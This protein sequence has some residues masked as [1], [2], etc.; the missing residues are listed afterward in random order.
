MKRK[1]KYLNYIVGAIMAWTA[2]CA[3]ATIYTWEGTTDGNWS[4]AANW[5]V[6]GIPIVNGDG[7]VVSQANTITIQSGANAPASNIPAFSS[8]THT[9]NLGTPRFN[10]EANASLTISPDNYTTEAS[11]SPPGVAVTIA[12]NAALTWENAGK[13]TLARN[14]SDQTYNITGGT[15]IFDTPQLNIIYGSG[16]ASIFNLDGGTLDLSQVDSLYSSRASTG[17]FSS[18][19]GKI[20]LMNGSTV[21]GATCRF[22]R[23]IIDGNP[24]MVFDIQDTN[25][26]I[27]I[28]KGD[29]YGDIFSL[30]SEFGSTFISST[31]GNTNLVATDE[32]SYFKVDASGVVTIPALAKDDYETDV[33]GAKPV[34]ASSVSPSTPGADLAVVVVGGSTNIAGTGQAVRFLDNSSGGG[35]LSYNL[36]ASA[37]TQKSAVQID[38]SFASLTNLTASMGISFS[39]GGYGANPGNGNNRHIYCS[40]RGDSTID[41]T[42]SAGHALMASN[43]TLSAFV[44]DHD[45]HTI[46]YEGPDASSSNTLAPNSVAYWLNGSLTTTA[47]MDDDPTSGGTVHNTTNN[48][49]SVSFSSHSSSLGVDYVI[50]DLVVTELVEFEGTGG[51]GDSLLPFLITFED[52]TPGVELTGADEFGHSDTSSNHIWVVGSSTNTAGTGNGLS[53]VD[54]DSSSGLQLDYDFVAENSAKVSAV[55]MDIKASYVTTNGPT[56][57][58]SIRWAVGNYGTKLGS[59]SLRYMAVAFRANGTVVYAQEISGSTA[60][61]NQLLVG[62]NEISMFV[63]DY[64]SLSIPY[65]GL[66]SSV[67]EL[68]PNKAAFWLNGS[69]V[70][71]PGG[72]EHTDLQLAAATDGGTIGTSEGNLGRVSLN[73]ATSFLG[74]NYIIDDIG[75]TELFTSLDG[76]SYEDWMNL[77]TNQTSEVELTD[78]PDGDGQE[79]LLEYAI[80]SSPVDPVST[81][82]VYNELDGG[83]NWLYHVYNRRTDASIRKLT[84][85]TLSGNELLNVGTTNV[86]S[87]YGVSAGSLGFESVTNRIPTDVDSQG[88]I[89]LEVE[90]TE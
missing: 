69:L 32:G 34:K 13:I 40:L 52:Q 70:T 26:V 19:W 58:P 33:L 44:N 30:Q 79:N 49:G 39:V 46:L 11:V 8:K 74:V 35:R 7:S 85:T 50:D 29:I 53:F 66:D 9:P 88:F 6:A 18:L 67:Y 5:S 20:N 36:S 27:T 25:S 12:T 89:T 21:D 14:V 86:L 17:D 2:S 77:Y 81:I 45:N 4:N 56:D 38:F 90:L 47:L 76:D 73:C 10:I 60:V 48:I 83:S 42:G 75:V 24:A 72:A 78:D 64:D 15:M 61:T 16:K 59:N 1:M 55:R 63:N 62:S 82:R 28:R 23:S 43:N 80:G 65:M 71:F 87:D 57:G 68:P 41:F 22:R 51:P 54:D 3:M 31:L 84:Y 37:A